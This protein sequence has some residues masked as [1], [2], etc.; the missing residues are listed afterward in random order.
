MSAGNMKRVVDI[1]WETGVFPDKI[2]NIPFDTF[3]RGEEGCPDP[4]QSQPEF[5]S[6]SQ[7]QPPEMSLEEISALSRATG[8][9]ASISMTA[10][11]DFEQASGIPT[12]YL[13]NLLLQ[14]GVD[15]TGCHNRSDLIEKLKALYELN[16][17]YEL[18]TLYPIEEAMRMINS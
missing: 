10:S 13:K 12:K 11:L 6:Q 3:L 15:I 17:H 4:D 5:Q 1:M 16:T 8:R 18:E 14:N 9:A 2:N 7:S